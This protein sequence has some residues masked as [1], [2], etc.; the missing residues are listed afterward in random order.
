MFESVQSLRKMILNRPKALNALN[1]EMISLI[2][3]QLTVRFRV[4]SISSG[5]KELTGDH[6]NSIEM[7]RI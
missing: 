5:K 4:V 3:P 1:S 6:L 2:Q 7:G